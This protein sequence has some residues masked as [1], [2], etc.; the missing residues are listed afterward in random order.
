MRISFIPL[1]ILGLFFI[2]SGAQSLPD[3]ARQERERQRA[4]GD[5]RIF[6]NENV[7][8]GGSVSAIEAPAEID[9][10]ASPSPA[11]LPGDSEGG[12]P[13]ASGEEGVEATGERTEDSW[14]QMF[15]DARDELTRSQERL[16]LTQQEIAD[17][18][19]RLLTE[20]SLYDRENQLG[21]EIQAKQEQ[22]AG[23]EARVEAANQAIADLQ[24]ELRRAG[25]PPG[26]G[27][28]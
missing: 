11:S 8:T 7:A 16:E 9:S 22:L 10:D 26:W 21:P 2:E 17:L 24:Q 4:V 28:P 15:A 25:A 12:E 20:S 6:T 1:L 3:V 5:G 19:Q 23:A 14:R 13:G 27:R 18:N